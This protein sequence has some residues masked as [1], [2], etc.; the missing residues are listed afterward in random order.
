[1]KRTPK[2]IIEKLLDLRYFT[3]LSTKQWNEEPNPEA[4]I[5]LQISGPR[6]A[7]LVVIVGEN[8]SGKSF[9]RRVVQGVHA[10][11]KRTEV[12]NISMEARRT[13]AYNPMLAFVYGDESWES[14][15]DNSSQTILGAMKTS[16]AREEEHSIFWDEPDLGL[17]DGWA[18]C[19]GREIARFMK[20]PPE[21]LLGAY[22][23]T[24]SKPLASELVKSNPIFIFVGETPRVESLQDWLAR[25]APVY[26]S[27]AE[28]GEIG[29]KR[30]LALEKLVPK[31]R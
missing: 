18:A 28:L 11:E 23:V 1:M 7:R 21:H 9:V 29:H 15:G 2:H 4:A 22:I 6:D 3:S 30:F 20:K 24:H 13:V 19:A 25:P 16:A 27:L 14:T 31:K 17:S 26:E 5:T 10:Q 12:I 8:A